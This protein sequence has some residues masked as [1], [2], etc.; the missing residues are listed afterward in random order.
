MN[1]SL[2]SMPV[3]VGLITTA[4]LFDFLNGLHD[5]ANSI[6]TVVATRVLR[7]L[8]AVL[9][10]SFFNFI[11][12][13]VFGLHVAATMGSGVVPPDLV[14]PQVV[15]GALTGAI[16]WN[17]VT[18]RFGIPSSS[19]H[20]LVGGL[21]GAG[22]A[23]AGSAAVVWNGVGI[24]GAAIVLSPLIGFLFAMGLVLGTAWVAKRATPFAVD[25]KF[26]VLQFVSSSL[27]SLAHGGNDAQK[28][29]GI[30]TVLLYSQGMLNG[31]FHV[32]MW[33]V[34]TC[35]G[36]MALGTLCGG[37]RIVR[38]VG[39]RITRLTPMQGFCAETGGALALFGATW[40]GIPVS[41]THTITGSIIGVGAARRT[42]AVR[43]GV[44]QNILLAWVITLPASAAVA[45]GCYW[46]TVVLAW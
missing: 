43:W 2:V 13:T 1:A 18:W 33:V 32:P 15:F 17:V 10:A 12:F 8:T 22:M 46:L 42:S 27:L 37:W 20:A 3:L 21:I 5:S 34:L 24:I 31:D 23:K 7:P 35:Q 6:A 16:V 4:L 44:T 9:W 36:A 11:A 28:T 29:M 19:S 26:R 30:I 25:R 39:S 40:L 14:D 38:T 45:A 41:T